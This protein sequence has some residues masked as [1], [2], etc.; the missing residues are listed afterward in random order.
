[1]PII[2]RGRGCFKESYRHS[3]LHNLA[4]KVKDVGIQLVPS[5]APA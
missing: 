5:N 1:M 4:Q 3:V 2:D